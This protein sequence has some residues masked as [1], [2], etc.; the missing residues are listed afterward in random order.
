MR[1]YRSANSLRMCTESTTA[2]GIRKI[3]IIELM[4][5]TVKPSPTISPMV[6]TMVTIARIIGAATSTRLRKKNHISRRTTSPASGAVTAI[7]V[8]ISTPNV[9][10]ATGRPVTW[11]CSVPSK[12]ATIA[13]ISPAIR[14]LSRLRSTGT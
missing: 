5:W 1:A 3:G 12:P 7:C 2:I 4:M 13:S 11:Y 10:S 8:N 14:R 6:A 9:S